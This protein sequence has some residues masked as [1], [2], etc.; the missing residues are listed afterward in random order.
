MQKISCSTIFF[1]LLITLFFHCQT[2]KIQT[3]N[4][5]GTYQNQRVNRME[6]LWLTLQNRRVTQGSSL[7]LSQDS[8]YYYK[9]CGAI[10]TG[11]WRAKQDSIYLFCET[12]R[13]R[14]DSLNVVG[15]N[16]KKL[17]C[18]AKPSVLYLRNDKLI[19]NLGKTK[20]GSAFSSIFKRSK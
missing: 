7:I 20:R 9:T 18:S 11:K 8:S 1:F 12:I 16:G 4:Y 2:R 5:I 15:F 13:Y 3:P 14:I 17:K 10:S 19:Q 6:A